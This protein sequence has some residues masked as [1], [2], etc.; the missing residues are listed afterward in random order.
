MYV[1]FISKSVVG[2]LLL[3]VALNF[4]ANMGF[5]NSLT[6]LNPRFVGAGPQK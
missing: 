2:G 6:T 1:G 5:L 3:R 4:T